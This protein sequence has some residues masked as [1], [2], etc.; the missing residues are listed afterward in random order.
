[1]KKLTVVILFLIICSQTLLFAQYETPWEIYSR[2]LELLLDG[3]KEAA[4]EIFQ[5]I[6]ENYPDTEAAA[7]ALEKIR[8]MEKEVDHSGIIPFY[9]GTMLT[10]TFALTTIPIILD[11]ENGI[12]LGSTGILGVGS[13]FYTAWLLSK[14]KD[15]TLGHDIWIEFIE[16][17]S[18]TNFQLFYNVFSGQIAND[19]TAEKINMGGMALT[20][21]GSRAFTY[22]SIIDSHPSGGRA[23]S[24]ANAYAWAQYYT[25]TTMGLVIESKNDDLNNLMAALIPDA[26]AVGMYFLWENLDWSL[27]RT[28]LIT[29]SGAGGGLLGIFLNM[30]IVE[31]FNS[32]L[33]DRLKS[34]VVMA[35]SLAGKGAGIY[36]TRNMKSDS[37]IR[38][39]NKAE[40]F[41]Q[42]SFSQG[43]A[44]F[45]ALI[46]Y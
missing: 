2:G 38:G 22:F 46:R 12:L 32:E 31:S 10:T 33:S 9:L 20:A 45:S 29:V 41:F 7:K 4:K 40:L 8:E 18:L 24:V 16:A 27:Q 14:E 37:H 25:W 23:F 19:D 34:S 28:G 43:A 35:F 44:G 30:I 5:N 36:F 1:M 6:S 15:L 39:Y 26:A 42:P 13:G 3:N 11:T 21:L 17:A